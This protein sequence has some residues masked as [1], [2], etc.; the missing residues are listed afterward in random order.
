MLN[1]LTSLRCIS[2]TE[3]AETISWHCIFNLN[4]NSHLNGW[5]F[6]MQRCEMLTLDESKIRK[7]RPVGLPYVGSKKKI[8][9]KIVQL[10][11]QNFGK[12]KTVYDIF[13]GGGAITAECIINGLDV[14][15]NDLDKTVVGMLE[16]V[17]KTDREFLK[18]LI[19]SRDDF[20]EILSKEEKTAEDNL[21]LL[22]NSFGN[23]S[24]GYIYNK[25]VSDIKYKTA[26]DVIHNHDVFYGYK[27]TE[28]YNQTLDKHNGQI[29]TL[30]QLERLQQLGRLQA[31]ER[32]QQLQ[33]VE[34]D[35]THQFT[36][37]DYKHF[38]NVTNAIIYLDPPYESTGKYYH[39]NEMN[40]KEFYDWAVKM[41]KNNIV[42]I[43]SYTVSDNR[44]EK[45][46]NFE[47]AR[48]TKQG[49]IGSSKN[50]KLFMVKDN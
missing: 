6:I 7:G 49:N 41:S 26:H 31:L 34:D 50:E 16:T 33:Y 10:I 35:A 28:M 25:E 18:T 30:K 32:L 9:K 2:V 13:G 20:F 48:S 3:V 21:K 12:D 15:Y 29:D 5:L 45:V 44:F 46:Y 4:N 17:L 11:I 22:I 23:D 24:K 27:Q 14:R 43:S 38:S 8:S 36:T 19:V 37:F 42:L 47:K 40:Y 1:F 39:E